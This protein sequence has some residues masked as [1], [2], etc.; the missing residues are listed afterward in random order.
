MQSEWTLLR[1]CDSADVRATGQLTNSEEEALQ[2]PHSVATFRNQTKY[3]INADH[4]GHRNSVSSA[5]VVLSFAKHTTQSPSEWSPSS[6]VSL[7]RPLTAIRQPSLLSPSQT[8]STPPYLA[9]PSSLQLAAN[10]S[11]VSNGPKSQAPADCV[12]TYPSPEVPLSPW[13]AFHSQAGSQT[14]QPSSSAAHGE[15]RGD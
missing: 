3:I 15:W 4:L 9:R 10:T 1:R 5:W 11:N 8:T 14:R 6:E 13:Q 7:S 12:C 2:P